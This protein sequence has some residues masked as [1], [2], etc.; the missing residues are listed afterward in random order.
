MSNHLTRCF[1][2]MPIF[3]GDE[4][5]CVGYVVPTALGWILIKS[6][7]LKQQ[8]TCTGGHWGTFRNV[9]NLVSVFDAGKQLPNMMCGVLP[10][11][12]QPQLPTKYTN[13]DNITTTGSVVLSASR[14]PRGTCV[15]GASRVGGESGCAVVVRLFS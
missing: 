12:Q 4:E 2:S 8:C 15:C 11:H 9:V 14:S 1:L 6:Q 3:L 10:R 13:S 7:Y 5:P